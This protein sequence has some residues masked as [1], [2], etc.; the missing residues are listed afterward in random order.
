MKI[1]Q[2]GTGSREK[3]LLRDLPEQG[4]ISKKET[5]FH[6]QLNKAYEDNWDEELNKLL[7]GIDDSAEQLN[8][9]KTIPA[10]K[11]YKENIR[12]FIRVITE[13]AY[14]LKESYSWNTRAGQRVFVLV[15][16]IDE[17]LEKLTAEIL[18][19]QEEEI[20]LLERLGEIR[21]LLVDLFV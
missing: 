7:K 1:G 19:Q 15:R 10:L 16:K 11:R 13:R 21:G 14:E 6:T 5:G 9:E 12:S 18:N 20:N 8:S 2:L 3:I 4:K 17:H